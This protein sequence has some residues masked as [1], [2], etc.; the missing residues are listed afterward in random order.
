MGARP[1]AQTPNP[2]LRALVLAVANTLAW[3]SQRCYFPCGLSLNST[4]SAV[5]VTFGIENKIRYIEDLSSVWLARAT[6]LPVNGSP[7]DL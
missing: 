6:D 4:T 5:I 3:S 1:M 7:T 2:I